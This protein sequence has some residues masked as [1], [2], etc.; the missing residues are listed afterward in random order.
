MSAS[1]A[2]T[3][4]PALAGA[5]ELSPP[6]PISVLPRGE[7]A[8]RLAGDKVNMPHTALY[9][10]IE[11]T[12]GKPSVLVIFVVGATLLGSAAA[13]VATLRGWHRISAVLAGVS[14]AL[15]L[16]VT[17]GRQPF[18]FGGLD[19]SRCSLSSSDSGL[20][21]TLL[22]VGMLMPLGFFAACATRRVLLPVLFCVTT[23]V[24]V[25]EAQ[26]IFDTGSCVAQDAAANTL[27]GAVG[28]CVGWVILRYRRRTKAARAVSD[29]RESTIAERS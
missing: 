15:A 16:A 21:E 12:V 2:R 23:S 24:L 20:S 19:F 17:Q 14:L 5:S 7:P 13:W 11:S 18:E 9:D 28:A 1:Q 3:L 22:N 29:N 10:L 27:G 26:A 25:E 6:I 4:R 8:I